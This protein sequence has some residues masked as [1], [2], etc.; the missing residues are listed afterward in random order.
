MKYRLL[1][2]L[3]ALIWGFAFVAQVIGMDS[4]GPYAFNG[5]RFLLGSLSLLPIIYYYPSG[6]NPKEASFSIW[7]A[8]LMA[9]ILLCGGATLQQVALQYTTA[10]KT[11]FLTATYLLMVPVIGLFFGQVLRL[12]HIFGVI[13]A[14]AGVYFISITETLDIGYGDFLV[15]LCAVCYAAH[16]ILLNYLTQRFPPVTL[17]SGQ[18]MVVGICNLILAF[19]FE[20]VSISSILSSWW[21][22]L[23]TG[24]LSTGVAYTLQAVGQKYL[25]ATE[26][27]MLLSCL[28]YTSDAADEEATMLLSLEMV[29]GG[30]CGVLFLNES[31][32][33]KQLIGI[34]CMTAGVFLA[35]IPSRTILPLKK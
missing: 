14:M 12:N 32:T 34:L 24:I 18:F 26:A 3:A 6:R 27:T 10:S 4:I 8:I 21:P 13:L 16:I 35:Q 25:P 31:F 5:I 11:S 1:L 23:Y 29:F 28:L 33:G 30:L 17:S 22:I 7:V 9:G 19:F 20:T 15:L 2:L